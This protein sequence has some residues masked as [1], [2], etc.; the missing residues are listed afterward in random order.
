MSFRL[1]V[2]D[3]DE[4]LWCT[5]QDGV[6]PIEGPF[7]LEASHLACSEKSRV[8]LRPGIRKLLRAIHRGGGIASLVCRSEEETCNEILEVFGLRDRFFHPRYGLQEKGE[9]I[10]EILAEIRQRLGVKISPEEVLLV[11]DAA[12]NVVEAQR[13]GARALLYGRD[14]RNLSE[15]Q[16]WVT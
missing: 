6:E 10:L 14:I 15:L 7:E 3:L 11:D 1:F 8:Q 13:V 2:F 9:A 4:T 16:K 12:A 5:D